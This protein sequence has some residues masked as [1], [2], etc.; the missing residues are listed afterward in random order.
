MMSRKGFFTNRVVRHWNEVH[1][2]P[3][4]ASSLPEFKVG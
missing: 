4:T 1:R 2:E 3:V